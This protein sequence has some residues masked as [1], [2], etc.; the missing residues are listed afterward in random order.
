MTALPLSPYRSWATYPWPVWVPTTTR[1]QLEDIWAT[2]AVWRQNS[3]SVRAPATGS[4]LHITTPDGDLAGQYI[5][6]RDTHGRLIPVTGKP[7]VVALIDGRPRW[8]IGR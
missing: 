2:P 7:I 3:R 4:M 8:V 1:V 5:H 6:I